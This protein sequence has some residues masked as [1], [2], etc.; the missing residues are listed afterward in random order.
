MSR[1]RETGA[2]PSCKRVKEVWERFYASKARMKSGLIT[3]GYLLWAGRRQEGGRAALAE[4]AL[5]RVS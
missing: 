5:L 1:T 3:K 2:S 4:W